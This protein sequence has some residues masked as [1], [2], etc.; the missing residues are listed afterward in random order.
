MKRSTEQEAE[1]RKEQALVQTYGKYGKLSHHNLTKYITKRYFVVSELGR[2][3][4]FIYSTTIF[5]DYKRPKPNY[6]RRD[7]WRS[8]MSPVE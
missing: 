7:T 5:S 4:L 8:G 1:K 3:I 2:S 6:I